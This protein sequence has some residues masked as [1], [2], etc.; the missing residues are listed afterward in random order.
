M[1]NL[2]EAVRPNQQPPPRRKAAAV[3][4]ALTDTARSR[5]LS[6]LEQQQFLA[7]TQ[8]WNDEPTR[9]T[10][11]RSPSGR[12]HPRAQSA[13]TGAQRQSSMLVQLGYVDANTKLPE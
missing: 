7:F 1:Y 6:R 13:R 12:P 4:A 5:M 11:P 8:P 2:R 3:L 10:A 9:P